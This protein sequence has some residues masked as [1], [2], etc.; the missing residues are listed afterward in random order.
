MGLTRPLTRLCGRSFPPPIRLAR[1]SDWV[2]FGR[3]GMIA[4]GLLMLTVLGGLAASERQPI[5]GRIGESRPQ[6]IARGVKFG[7]RSRLTPHQMKATI[8]RRDVGEPMREIARSYNVGR[9]AISRL[10]A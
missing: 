4:R 6:V 2:P 8:K 9:S 10:V 1:S 7:Q 5:R 3:N